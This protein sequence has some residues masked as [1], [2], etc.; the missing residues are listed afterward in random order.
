MR[1]ALASA[2]ILALT[3]AAALTGC[4]A[5]DPVRGTIVGKDYEP[6]DWDTQKTP[7][8]KQNCTSRIVDK[9]SITTCTQVHDGYNR[10]DVYTPACH[11]LELEDGREVCVDKDVWNSLGIGETYD[12]SKH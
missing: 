10:V 2:A 7:R 11:E 4:A 1:K 5:N 9:K 12:S 8:Y 3:T 6:E